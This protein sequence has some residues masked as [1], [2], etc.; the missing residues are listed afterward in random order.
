MITSVIAACK[1]KNASTLADVCGPAAQRDLVKWQRIE[2]IRRSQLAFPPFGWAAVSQN[3]PT[4]YRHASD[5]T[6]VCGR[7]LMEPENSADHY[8]TSHSL[9]HTRP[10][11]LGVLKA[12]QI[13]LTD[14]LALLRAMPLRSGNFFTRRLRQKHCRVWSPLRGISRYRPMFLANANFFA[15]FFL[16]S[17]AK[18]ESFHVPPSTLINTS[19]RPYPSFRSDSSLATWHLH[20][21]T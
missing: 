16:F 9:P 17:D 5:E 3:L 4:L 13:R 8:A 11:C 19:F 12:R 1:G 10:F 14:T 6:G 15:H 21:L 7:K 2:S 20:F 18:N